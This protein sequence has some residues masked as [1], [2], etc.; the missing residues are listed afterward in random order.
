MPFQEINPQKWSTSLRTIISSW[1]FYK[2]R[3][4]LVLLVRKTKTKTKKH[5]GHQ[6]CSEIQCSIRGRKVAVCMQDRILPTILK[7]EMWLLWRW[8]QWDW[9]L[10]KWGS[11]LFKWHKH[12]HRKSTLIFIKSIKKCSK[13][14]RYINKGLLFVQQYYVSAFS[15]L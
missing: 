3:I 14:I 15:R 6:A 4:F 5:N 10:W 9:V 13:E 12:W 7:A 11:Y 8:F 2:I 1:V